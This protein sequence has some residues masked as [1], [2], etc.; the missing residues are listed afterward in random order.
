VGGGLVE[1]AIIFTSTLLFILNTK[2]ILFMTG[3][4]VKKNLVYLVHLVIK[5]DG[6]KGGDFLRNIYLTRGER[7]Q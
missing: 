7:M 6:E 5:I 4:D 1:C 2:D 3:E